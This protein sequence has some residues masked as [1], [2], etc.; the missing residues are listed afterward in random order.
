MDRLTN[1]LTLAASLNGTSSDS[2]LLQAFGTQYYNATPHNTGYVGPSLEAI[3]YAALSEQANL[4][5]RWA[6]VYI[7]T[8]T[9]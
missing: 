6:L 1:V 5:E 7:L 8:K 3:K 4:R 9:R 2:A